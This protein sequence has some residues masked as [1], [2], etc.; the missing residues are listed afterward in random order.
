[1]RSTSLVMSPMVKT[2]IPPERSHVSFRR[3]QTWSEKTR[4]VS[5]AIRSPPGL[6]RLQ[7]G[8]LAQQPPARREPAGA[9][10]RV[11][12]ALGASRSASR[13]ARACSGR[14]QTPRRGARHCS[15]ACRQ[16][17]HRRSHEPA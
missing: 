3:L 9:F 11:P 4:P 13:S 7:A 2:R 5:R 10:F 16:D 17:A 12:P 1:M 15:G 14:F 6:D 8:A